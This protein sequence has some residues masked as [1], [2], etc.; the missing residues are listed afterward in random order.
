MRPNFILM[1]V[2]F[3]LDASLVQAAF[4]PNV[5]VDHQDIP[6]YCYV[7]QVVVWQTDTAFPTVYVVFERDSGLTN[8]ADVLFQKST[9]GG[10]T[11]LPE[12]LVLH[13][14]EEWAQ[15]PFIAL[16]Q[17][18]TI[19]VTF[20]E[21]TL[22]FYS[23][24]LSV[25]STDGGA[26]WQP[27]VQVDD[28]AGEVM[29]AGG[30]LAVDSV[31]D[32]ICAYTDWR[33]DTARVW[34]S[35]STDCGAS[36]Q[37]SVR[38]TYD[39]FAQSEYT[40]PVVCAQ[41]GTGDY[42]L[43]T[44]MSYQRDTVE[45]MFPVLYRSTDRGRTW[46]G[47]IWCD[48]LFW[49]MQASVVADQEH[50]Y[51]AW[52][53]ATSD[54]SSSSNS[55][56]FQAYFP[57]PDTWGPVVR[58]ID[59]ER[60]SPYH[61]PDLAV[62]LNGSIHTTQMVADLDSNWNYDIHYRKSTDGGATWPEFSI[63]NDTLFEHQSDPSLAVD[64]NGCAYVAWYDFRNLYKSQIWFATDRELAIEESR[65][66]ASAEFPEAST[67]ARGLLFLPEATSRKFQAASLLDISGR[68]VMAL[69]SGPNDVR[70]LAPGVYFVRKAQA[71]AVR[72]VV[73]LR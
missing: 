56:R 43:I 10:R 62:A 18:G 35:L 26:T 25:R 59:E 14:G 47:G 9:N 46:D 63:V 32:V 33:T 3:L 52:T 51:C 49:T 60:Y 15:D 16:G 55:T 66:P 30:R 1:S 39:T 6:Y 28:I 65:M 48:S 36:W 69:R 22:E 5:R 45:R 73:L 4:G 12:D 20:R 7:P 67:I 71:Q 2:L 50:V 23:H 41:P 58:V 70:A 19:I 13:Y 24:T 31:G 37:P 57:E 61:E 29:T 68:K 40:H 44:K 21:K 72:K 11:W 64:R 42:Y 17:D 54:T 8:R 27:P 53:G 34:T 38:V